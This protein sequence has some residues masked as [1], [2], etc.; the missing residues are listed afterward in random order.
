[1]SQS[2]HI[3]TGVQVIR[4]MAAQ[5]FIRHGNVIN[6]VLYPNREWMDVSFTARSLSFE[7]K[8]TKTDAGIIYQSAV[9]FATTKEKKPSDFVLSELEPHDILVKLNYNNGE[10]RLVGGVDFPARM[11]VEQDT[12]N[13]DVYRFKIS[14]TS[15]FRSVLF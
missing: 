12:E 5:S 14:C 13:N 11:I 1:M 15:I 3:I 9:Q 7:E 4:S 10:S 2:L 6:L 8:P